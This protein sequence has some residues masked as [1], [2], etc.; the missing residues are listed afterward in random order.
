MALVDAQY[1]FIYV[2]VGVN[3]RVSDGGVFSRCSLNKAIESNSLHIPQHR[4]LPG[5]EIPCPFHI[6]A[7]EAFPLRNNI[8][9]PFP[10]RNMSKEQRVYNYR[11]SRGRR[12]VENAFG[13]LSQRFRCLVTNML[14]PPDVSENVVL[15]TCALHNY[16]IARSGNVKYMQACDIDAEDQDTHEVTR[17]EWRSENPNQSLQEISRQAGSGTRHCG[18]AKELRN[19]LRDYFSSAEGEVSWQNDMIFMN[20]N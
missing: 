14:L 2:D 1:R 8:M 15:A 12:V 7:D 11:I 17:G 19:T 5:T 13:I 3:G 6:I 10:F 18:N 4:P 20:N 9:K 16:L